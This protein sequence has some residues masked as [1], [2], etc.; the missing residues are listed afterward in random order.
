MARKILHLDLDAFFCAVEELNDPSL[1]GKPF[2]VGGNANQRGVVASCS[3]AARMFGVRSAMPMSRALRLCPDLIVLSSRHG[4]YSEESRKVMASIEISPFIEQISID[5]AFIEVTDLPEPLIA[6]AKSLQARINNELKLPVSFGGGT[7]KLIAKI[8]NDWGKSQK[9]S[10]EPP[11]AITIIPP[12]EEAKFLAPLPVQSLW[13]IGPKTAD[14]LTGVGIK[15]IGA[16]ANAPSETLKMLFG[17]YGP[18]LRKRALG[19]DNRPLETEHDV[20]SVSNEVTFPTDK[21]DEGEILHI[22]RGLSE[23]VGRRLRR[24]ALVGST[25]HIKLR[26]SNFTTITRQVTLSSGTN[27][28]QEIYETA[29][30]LFYENWPDGKPIRLIGIGVSNLGPPVHQ[31]HLWE[32]DHQ[33]EA[34]LLN[35]VDDLRQRFGRDII[36]RAHHLI[37][38]NEI[39]H[40]EKSRK[41]R[42]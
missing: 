14:K 24:N 38:K 34:N 15:T 35:A 11:N 9:K 41:E 16:L 7:N 29:K 18:E 2:A 27:L 30:D 19:I 8:A 20:K 4:N 31:L 22:I 28:D 36:K 1:K 37:K 3:Y 39:H 5:E 33:K 6:I 12:G 32:D 26:W 21:A 23:Q 25:I 40:E 10:I 42:Q 13:G 17:R